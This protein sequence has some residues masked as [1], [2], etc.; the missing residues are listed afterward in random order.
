MNFNRIFSIFFIFILVFSNTPASA[1]WQKEKPETQDETQKDP[2]EEPY[3]PPQTD[4]QVLKTK[5]DAIKASPKDAKKWL[6]LGQHLAGL[7]RYAEA[8]KAFERNVLRAS[9][10][11][12]MA[13]YYTAKYS[14]LNGDKR[15][16]WNI[17]KRLTRDNKTPARVKVATDYLVRKYWPSPK[18][19]FKTDNLPVIYNFSP[20]FS[21]LTYDGQTTKS[22][23]EAIGFY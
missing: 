17:F 15:K 20:F 11:R 7:E 18:E 21:S 6:D 3:V 23:G 19:N 1:Q 12:Y 9:H 14:F 5:M 10:Y 8:V 13:R 2:Q 16:A 22:E 4:N